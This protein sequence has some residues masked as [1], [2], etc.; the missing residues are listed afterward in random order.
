MSSDAEMRKLQRLVA[1]LES[2]DAF[3]RRD[4]IEALEHA[5]HQ[6]L[7][8]DWGAPPP[9]RERAVRRWRR[10]LDAEAERRQGE[11]VQATLQLLA[12]GQVDPAA[13][14]K[15]LKTLPAEQKKAL[16]A[17]LVIAKAAAEAPQSAKP[18]VSPHALCE[19][20]AK[21]PATVRVTERSP[22]GS[23]I[24]RVLCEVCF[25]SA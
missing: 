9:D 18:H 16:L 25:G 17:Q 12:Q 24:A 13:F 23:W 14:Q 20:C 5:T 8:F 6:R 15:L 1:E 11:E 19:R 22:A 10:W 7:G 3:E 2:A 4:A 21:N